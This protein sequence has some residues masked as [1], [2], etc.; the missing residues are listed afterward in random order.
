MLHYVQHDSRSFFNGL[1]SRALESFLQRG[2]RR[3]FYELNRFQAALFRPDPQDRTAR[4]ALDLAL[5]VV[6]GGVSQ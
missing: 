6:L 2:R 1:L 4:E 3:E 5:V